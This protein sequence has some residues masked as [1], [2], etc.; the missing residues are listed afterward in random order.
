MAYI[1][2]ITNNINQKV[3]IGQTIMAP[4]Q[5][6]QKH[7]SDARLNRSYPLYKAMNKYGIN[8]FSF[9]VLEEVDIEQLNEKERYYINLYNSYINADNSNGYNAT[10]GGSQG[11]HY[12]DPCI[13]DVIECARHMTTNQMANHFGV[14]YAT[15]KNYLHNHNIQSQKGKTGGG[16]KSVAQI[17]I[18]TDEI[19]QVFPSI[20]DASRFFNKTPKNSGIRDVLR[21]KGKTAYGYKWKYLSD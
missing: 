20:A 2:K 4:M 12:F 1:Y 8:N 13:N 16:A 14:G 15:M 18:D 21:G 5:R 6:W 17:D 9:E 19:I 3:Y 10:L 11:N 7:K